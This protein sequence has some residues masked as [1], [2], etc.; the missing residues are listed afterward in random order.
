MSGDFEIFRPN[1]SAPGRSRKGKVLV[2]ADTLPIGEP[3]DLDAGA[4]ERR[5]ALP[6]CALDARKGEERVGEEAGRRGG[7]AGGEEAE[8]DAMSRLLFHPL[9]LFAGVQGA[10][11]ECVAPFAS[12][13]VPC[14][15]RSSL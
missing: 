14:R 12:F 2:G 11:G 1:I 9:F 3:D 10:Q 6:L 7:G 8:E 15:R 13:S 4:S 5:H